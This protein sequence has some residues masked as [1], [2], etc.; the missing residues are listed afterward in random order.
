LLRLKSFRQS[1][2]KFLQR[3]FFT[4]IR[5]HL[6]LFNPKSTNLINNQW[7]GQANHHRH[8]NTILGLDQN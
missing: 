2:C 8:T 4:K 5:R 3:H 6:R 1:L 7:P